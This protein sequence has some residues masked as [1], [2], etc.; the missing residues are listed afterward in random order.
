MTYAQDM[1]RLTSAA[2]TLTTTPPPAAWSLPAEQV[3]PVLAARD[4]V[5][6]A[7]RDLA[8]ALLLAAPNTPRAAANID[9]VT[10]P[11][12]GDGALR[13][14]QQALAAL[15]PAVGAD[16]PN[17][18]QALSAGGGGLTQAWRGAARAA[19]T[20][21]GQHTAAA[22]AGP[23]DAW[24]VTRDLAELCAA[25][26][27]LDTD[28]A[29]ALPPGHPAR[30]A[31]LHADG[32][33]QL[34]LAAEHLAQTTDLTEPA[35]LPNTGPLPK[36]RPLTGVTDL[37]AATAHLS[38]LV[39]ARGPDLTATEARAASKALAA[40]IKVTTQVLA[41]LPGPAAA[42]AAAHWRGAA[43]HLPQ[44]LQ[45]QLA[46]LT[47]PAPGVRMLA[48]QIVDQLSALAKLADRLD[49][50]APGSTDLPRR[51]QP[52]ADLLA[53]WAVPAAGLAEN[54]H[55][56]LAQAGAAGHLLT[57]RQDLRR[58]ADARLL[59]LPLPP[60]LTGADPTV[61]AAGSTATALA[62]ATP[63][64]RALTQHRS[65]PTTTQP[66]AA[67]GSPTTALARLRSAIQTRSASQL[68]PLPRPAHPALSPATALP[69]HAPSGQPGGRSRR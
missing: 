40:G 22:L 41:Q 1:A 46:T 13:G 48:E 28:L 45:G 21:E 16:R 7:L 20:L 63:A 34:R 17:L 11:V 66:S 60:T 37:P 5:T 68:P 61:L 54:L 51:L 56:S 27:Y 43:P 42:D 35:T 26:P 8:A 25:L 47:P 10:K 30:A 59:W 49:N 31:L 52:L 33:G 65:S 32:H 4:T 69:P 14:L 64:L 62:Q 3:R 55:S 39:H 2:A 6:S 18:T 23:T 38:A 15:Q 9:A 36:A 67:S 58:G 24:A 57:P 50:A 19:A 12:A 29:G 53:R 44:L